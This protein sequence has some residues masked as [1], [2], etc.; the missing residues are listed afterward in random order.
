MDPKFYNK[1]GSLTRY[2]LSC[3]YVQ[4]KGNAELYR[5][6]SC[7]HVV[8]RIDGKIV[9]EDTWSLKEA[10]AHLRRLGKK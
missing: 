5:E 6:H 8:A 2:A 10:R 7:Y 9:R 4:Q 1:D 3:G